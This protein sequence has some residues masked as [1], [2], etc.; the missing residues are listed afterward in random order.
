[1][2]LFLA[3]GVVLWHCFPI[4]AGS[5][6]L[7]EA[8]P[9]WF[10]VSSMVPMFFAV[11]GFL[12]I[13]SATR[14][15]VGPF[16]M[17][18]VA[19]IFPALIVVVGLMALA[20]GPLISS[21]PPGIYFESSR[22]WRYLA[23]GLGLV[24]F[25]LPGVFEA[26]PYARVV[27]GSL[28]TVPHEILCYLMVAGLMILGLA[29]R[30][31]A[32]T[33]LF[34]LIF[35]L[36]FLG[37]WAP[38]GTL[39]GPVEMLVRS[40]HFAQ[41]S[42]IIPFFLLGAIFYLARGRIPLDWRLAALS[43]VAVMAIGTLVDPSARKGALLWLAAGPPLTYLTVWAGMVRLPKPNFLG[44]GDFSYGVYLWHFPILQL[45]VMAFGIGSWWV[46][47]LASILPVM[48]VAAASWHFVEKPALAWRKR[49]SLAGA[50]AA[51][52]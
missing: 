17:N 2:R 50:R 7:I 39:P 41:G 32:L 23:T 44:G 30:W 28:W 16:L 9:F 26:N 18:R 52:G 42:K 21:V 37:Q 47:G 3:S 14:V 33:L 38:V 27:N 43:L 35:L 13:A 46:L 51:K 34:A 10:I 19:R 1:M 40:P 49:H 8:T 25:D 20:V 36:A 45:L 29:G 48:L 12:V 22:L 6:R 15:P 5:A 11:S 4:T 31:W 24:S